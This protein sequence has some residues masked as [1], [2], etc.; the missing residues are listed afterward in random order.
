MEQ[1][2]DFNIL[3]VHQTNEI[4]HNDVDTILVEIAMVAEGE[5]VEFEALGLDHPNTRDI[6]DENGAVIGL[7]CLRA[8]RG[9]LRT[10]ERDKIVILRVLVDKSLQ[11]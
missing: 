4:L 5:E 10:M 7:P 11:Q 6:R 1:A 9:E 8:K 3:R 2:R